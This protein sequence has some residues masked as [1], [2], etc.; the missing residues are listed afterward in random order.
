MGR[1]VD[2]RKAFGVGVLVAASSFFLLTTCAAGRAPAPFAERLGMSVANAGG[3]NEI[4]AQYA[5][6]FGAAALA[7]L[8]STV[9]VLPRRGSYLVLVVIFGGLS[10]GRLANTALNAGVAGY[11]AAVTALHV[12]DGTGLVLAVAALALDRG[13]TAPAYAPP[14]AGADC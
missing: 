3:S 14:R 12:I 6:F 8:A 2:P 10:A 7:C 13:P 5:G 4:R 11:T 1:P 9:G